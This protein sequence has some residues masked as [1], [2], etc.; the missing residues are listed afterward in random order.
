MFRTDLP[1]VSEVRISA[2]GRLAAFRVQPSERDVARL[3][4]LPVAGGAPRE[5]MTA[6]PPNTLDWRI[7]LTADP[8]CGQESFRGSAVGWRSMVAEDS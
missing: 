1:G 6:Q 8:E 2:D 3:L 5:L 7:E 4:V